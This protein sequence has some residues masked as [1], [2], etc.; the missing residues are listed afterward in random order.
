[1]MSCSGEPFGGSVSVTIT[2]GSTPSTSHCGDKENTIIQK[3]KFQIFKH[4]TSFSPLLHT[5]ALTLHVTVP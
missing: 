2:F 3:F 5:S 4:S 1:M